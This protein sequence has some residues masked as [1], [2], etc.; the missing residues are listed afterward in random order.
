MCVSPG[1]ADS[2]GFELLSK[3]QKESL[4]IDASIETPKLHQGLEFHKLWLGPANDK[5]T[6]SMNSIIRSQFELGNDELLLQM[7]IE[8][9]ECA[10][11]MSTDLELLLKFRIVVIEFHD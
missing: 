11:L 8:G 2:W 9:A 5:T 7:D 10:S 4:M 1:V 6:L 3:Y